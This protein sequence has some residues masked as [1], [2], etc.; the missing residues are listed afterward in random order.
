VLVQAI[1]AA[2]YR[3]Q[4]VRVTA[5]IKHRDA[6]G[7]LWVRVQT[8]SSPS[9]GPGLSWASAPLRGT[10]DWRVV[11]L[12]VDVPRPGDSIQIGAG[13]RG[14]GTLWLD[15]VRVAAVAPDVPLTPAPPT[16]S[17]L[18]NGDFEAGDEPEGWFL[19]GDA[20]DDYAAS[21]DRGEH[22][23]GAASVRLR[24]RVVAPTGYATIMQSVPASE[25]RGKR[26]RMT[27][28]VKAAAAAGHGGLWLRVQAA[29]SPPDGPGLGGELCRLSASAGWQP[30]E[31]VFDV[32]EAASAIQIG[33]GL[34]G[35][36]TLWLD[37][38]TL[39]EVPRDVAVT[40][41]VRATPQPTNLD[42]ETVA[43][44]E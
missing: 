4:R 30:C 6:R 25:L 5:A 7:E 33:L 14:R 12:V 31:V 13:L 15:D 20:H 41:V 27:A 42:F 23:H 24:P 28:Q 38:V 36:G 1:A 18:C 9:D 19:S 26:V 11:E 35:T 21:I 43:P 10:A 32:P 22:A 34:A 29:Y 2:D 17:T 37:Q 39:A 40:T 3:G 44:S 16:P 8:A